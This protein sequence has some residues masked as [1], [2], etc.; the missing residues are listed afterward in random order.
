[1]FT[2]DSNSNSSTYYSPEV[3]IT[4]GS[5]GGTELL[6]R[7][8]HLRD[9]RSPILAPAIQEEETG[10]GGRPLLD[11]EEGKQRRESRSF[12]HLPALCRNGW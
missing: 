5:G 10:W 4:S 3:G 8:I 11:V 2:G 6:F 7:S 9:F 12:S 1:M